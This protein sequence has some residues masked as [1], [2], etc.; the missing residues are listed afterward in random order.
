MKFKAYLELGVGKGGSFLLN[1]LFQPYLEKSYC[2]DN[3]T[4]Y[5]DIQR[6]EINKKIEYLKRT[7]PLINVQFFEGATESLLKDPRI[8][9]VFDCIFID[10]DHS[11]EGCKKDYES[12]LPLLRD[13]G[14]LIFHDINSLGAPGIIKFWSEI[15]NPYCL[16]FIHSNTCGIGIY[17]KSQ[18][19]LI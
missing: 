4:Y 10:A 12:S 8:I 7:R 1:T 19:Q 9:T 3:C 13:T 5:A 18:N 14:Y 2:I 17:K 6:Y 15:K 11:Y 16:E